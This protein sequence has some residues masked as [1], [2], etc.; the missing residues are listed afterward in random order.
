MRPPP[1]SSS[2]PPLIHSRQS[3]VI[4][5]F[6]QSLIQGRSGRCWSDRPKAWHCWLTSSTARRGLCLQRDPRP[7]QSHL[8][9]PR[10]PGQPQSPGPTKQALPKDRRKD[11]KGLRGWG[12]PTLVFAHQV[13][14]CQADGAPPSTGGL[15]EG[16]SQPQGHEPCDPQASD[17]TSP[18]PALPS[19]VKRGHDSAWWGPGPVLS[20]L[21]TAQL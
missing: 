3:D 9:N 18:G 1:H 4:H 11:A 6:I 16:P 8:A 15:G 19:R 5:S 12:E 17:L 13:G 7:P 2:L 10:L 20:T 21:D 14:P